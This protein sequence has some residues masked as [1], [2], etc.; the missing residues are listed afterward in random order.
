MVSGDTSIRAS[1]RGE[2]LLLATVVPSPSCPKALLP[3]ADRVP[4][5]FS[6]IV[7][8]PPLPALNQSLELVLSRSGVEWVAGVASIDPLPSLPLMLLPHDHSD[9]SALRATE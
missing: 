2:G 7:W 9:P 1:V 5:A 3:Q 4:P 6:A 8:L